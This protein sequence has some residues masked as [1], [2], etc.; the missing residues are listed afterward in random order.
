MSGKEPGMKIIASA[1]GLLALGVFLLG[2]VYHHFIHFASFSFI[3]VHCQFSEPVLHSS[4]ENSQQRVFRAVS[5]T[6]LLLSKLK[7]ILES[8]IGGNVVRF[9][10]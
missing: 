4:V 6:C 9:L 10:F 3:L 5:C 7:I 2:T 8:V 1:T